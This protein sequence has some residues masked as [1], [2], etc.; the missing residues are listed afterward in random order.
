[1]RK[2]FTGCVAFALF[3]GLASAQAQTVLNP[4]GLSPTGDA[5]N[6]T[7]VATG[8]TTQNLASWLGSLVFYAHVASNGPIQ[9]GFIYDVD[10]SAPRTFSLPSLSGVTPGS[11]IVIQ[12]GFGQAYTNPITINV[13]GYDT[14][15]N[16]SSPILFEGNWRSLKLIAVPGSAYWEVGY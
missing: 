5:S 3:A 16:V 1:M 8:G 7:V 2:L 10:T 11:F 9:T 14:I 15:K 6:T 12:D 4:P 13:N